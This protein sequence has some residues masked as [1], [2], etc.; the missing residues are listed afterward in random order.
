VLVCHP[1]ERLW[2]GSRR[3][4]AIAARLQ[5]GPHHLE[6][7][8]RVVDYQNRLVGPLIDRVVIGVPY[9]QIRY[10]MPLSGAARRNRVIRLFG[11]RAHQSL[12][13]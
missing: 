1:L 7:G 4:H 13:Q 2:A 11:T 8:R 9:V 5:K 3:Q 12:H 6:I 10:V